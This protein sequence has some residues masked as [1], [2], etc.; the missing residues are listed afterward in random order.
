MNLLSIGGSDPSS[1][2]G[3]QADVKTFGAYDAY[4]LTITTAL[5]AQNT[6]E[7]VRAEPVS[8]RMLESQFDVILSDFEISGIKI[9]MVYT[10]NAAKIIS[11]KIS[12]MS[13]KIPIVIDP[14]I[15]S[16]T[17]G[18]LLEESALKDYIHY[19]ASQATII[20]PNQ[21]EACIL[22]GIANQKNNNNNYFTIAS[23]IIQI[24]GAKSAMITGIQD[25]NINKVTDVIAERNKNG[26]INTYQIAEY[27]IV[28]NETH[29][30]GCAYSAALLCELVSGKTIRE[31]SKDAQ[32]FVAQCIQ[33]PIKVGTGIQI[34]SADV[35]DSN[36]L[37]LTH[38]VNKFCQ[39]KD[40]YKCIPEC[41]TNFVYANKNPHNT[42]N[43]LGI[44]GR[45][46]RMGNTVAMAGDIAYGG[47]KHV[48]TALITMS[49]KFSQVQSAINIKYSQDT[50]S[51]MN[52]AKM[53]ITHYDRRYEPREIKSDEKNSTNGSTIQWGITQAIKDSKTIPDAVC[54]DGDYGKEPMIIIFGITPDDVILKINKILSNK[55]K[56]T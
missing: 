25:M 16:T 36:R 55:R 32:R 2:A 53:H 40:A 37:K 52:N 46:I 7:F 11:K 45:I 28:K 47:S 8:S 44:Q 14:V 6:V 26:D 22:L 19:I 27:P 30:G 48:A 12:E 9:G 18:V 31:S 24:T 39:L 41:Q 3:I 51:A 21:Q 4:A 29:G 13:C 50:I 17:G 49:K 34:I 54:H 5:T 23:D 56:I 42:K 38:A 10:S 35:K 43:V 1:G 15:Y 33:N 20:T